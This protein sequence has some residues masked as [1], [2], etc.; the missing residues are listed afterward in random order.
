MTEAGRTPSFAEVEAQ[1]KRALLGEGEICFSILQNSP[2]G[3]VVIDKDGNAIYMNP[4]FVRITGYT[5]QDIPTGRQWLRKAYPDPKYREQVLAYW[6]NALTAKGTERVVRVTC[7]DGS[8]KD[9]LFKPAL[10]D[11]GRS[12][13]VVS[14][15]TERTRGVTR[16]RESEGKYRTIFET[17]GTATII[18]EGDGVISLANTEFERLS[19]YTKKELDG[20]KSFFEF[21][22][23][24]DSN[25]V[26]GYHRARR[27]KPDSAPRSYE[28]HFLDRLGAKK[29]TLITVAMIP[30]TMSSVGSLLDVTEQKAN[31]VKLQSAFKTFYDIIETA[32]IG[33]YVVNQNGGI[34]YVNPAMY[35]ISGMTERQF[36]SQNVFII[37]EYQR[38]GL[39][40]KIKRGLQ[41]KRFK[42]NSLEITGR[43]GKTTVRNYIGMPFD[44]GDEKKLLMFVEDITEQKFNEEKLTYIATHDGLT[45]LPNRLLFNDRLQLALAYA[46]RRREK[47]AVM[48]LD[49]DRFKDVNDNLGHNVGDMLLQTVSDR[50]SEILRKSDTVARMG[51]DEFLMLLPDV[52]APEDVDN[53]ARKILEVFNKPFPLEGHEIEVTT[54]IGIAIYPDNGEDI[55]SL[56]KN[57]DVAM[58]DVKKMG[59]NGFRRFSELAT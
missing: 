50:L 49:L 16:L 25:R 18:I 20:K 19:G 13:A 11:H 38:T 12:F 52:D 30:G 42:V 26:A 23:P 40:E 37:P 39:S 55:D 21:V 45:G 36:L 7:G 8:I 47:I 41:G 15:V 17:T 59:R 10:L 43:K 46:Q 33:I 22:A 29:N 27:T 56:V 9:I 1:M 53:V 35:K 34:Q 6:K 4:E 28:F 57:A 54:S 3:V 32:P 58:Y 44:Q 2:Y 5:L 24:E 51:G 48:L 14:D 31:Q